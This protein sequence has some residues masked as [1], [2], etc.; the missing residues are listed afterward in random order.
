MP[1]FMLLSGLGW[2][3]GAILGF[4]LE[5]SPEKYPL[6]KNQKTHVIQKVMLVDCNCSFRPG[7]FLNG[8]ILC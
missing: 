1:F 4:V 5:E 2:G 6:K 3:L 7:G 8:F